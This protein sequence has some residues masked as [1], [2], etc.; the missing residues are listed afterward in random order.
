VRIIWSLKRKHFLRCL[1]CENN[2]ITADNTDLGVRL[3]KFSIDL[4]SLQRP[5]KHPYPS[6]LFIYVHQYF[7]RDRHRQINVGAYI[8][9]IKHPARGAHFSSLLPHTSLIKTL[10]L[11]QILL[12]MHGRIAKLIPAV[13]FILF[14]VCVIINDP[15]AKS[16]I[17]FV[18][19][20]RH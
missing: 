6:C 17:N 7:E 19:Y 1:Q 12:L 3:F 9:I 15:L 14:V 4:W 11:I 16:T 20:T 13:D 18:W 10:A 2:F 8:H 5:P